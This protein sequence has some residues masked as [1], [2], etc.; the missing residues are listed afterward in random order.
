MFNPKPTL[1]STA[2][3]FSLASIGANAAPTNY[4]NNNAG[5]ITKTSSSSSYDV[6]FQKAMADKQTASGM[7][8]HF[9]SKL[10]K[11]TFA[12]APEGMAKPSLS[13]VAE[14]SKMQVAADFYL[15]ELTG[16][17]P[18]KGNAVT[19]KLMYMHDLGKG[20]RIAK[21]HQEIAGVEVF[22]REYNVMLDA[23]Y[24]LVAGSG[25]FSQN[26]LPQGQIAPDF[27]FGQA[28]TAIST[29][30]SDMS[31]GQVNVQL[32]PSD[33]AN[34][35]DVFDASASV[36]SMVFDTK[37]RAKK[38]YFDDDNGLV[39]AYYVEVSIADENSVD[40]TFYSY[41]IN[42]I[43]GKILFKHDLVAHNDFTYRAYAHEDGYP[44]QG[45]N[46]DVIPQLQPG[47]DPSEILDAP[48]ITLPFYSTLSTQ[49]PWLD[50]DATTT[51]G[52][53]AFAY[54]DVIAPQGFTTGD[55]TAETTAPNTFDYSINT[56]QRANSFDNRKAAIVNLFYMSNF[57]HDYYYDY[58]FDEA[59]GNAQLS[60]FDRGGLGG[61]PL[62]LE[63]QDSSGLN[64]ANMATPADG[65]S[66]RMQQFLWNDKDAVVGTDWGTTVTL[67]A[68][69][70]L[71][72]SSQLASFGALQY[73]DIVGEVVRLIDGD[74]ALGS[75]TDGCEA[76]TNAADLVGKIAIID[77]G[78]CNFTVKVFNAQQAGAVAALVVNNVDDGTPAPMGGEDDAVTIPSMGLNFEEG[79]IIY[80]EIDSDGTIEVEMFSNFPLRDSTF[81]NAIIAHE[82]GHYI[83]NR[84]IGNASGLT[85]FQGRAMGEGWAD[86]H[87]LLFVTSEEDLQLAG[88]DQLQT[89]YAVGSFVADFFT[90][91]RRAPYSTN[92]DINPLSFEDITTGAVPE[93]LTETTNASPHGAGEVWAVTLWDMYVSLVNTHGFDEG[94]DRM[95]RYIIEGYKMTPISPTY[96]EARDAILASVLATNPEDFDQSIAVFARRGMGLGAVSPD[97]DDPDLTGVVESNLTQLASFTGASVELNADFDGVTTGFCTA[98]G[99]LDNGET[100]T[101]TVTINNNGSEAL[102][103]I[104]G[105]LVVLSDHEVSFANDGLVEFESVSAFTSTSVSD[106]EITMLGAGTADTLEIEVQFPEIT[107]GD[108]TIQALPL[109]FTTLVNLDFDL[110]AP[111][112]GTSVSDMETAALF[113]DFSEN[114]IVGGSIA[115]GTLGT[116]TGN[117]SFFSS[118]NP[119]VD[120]G[121]QTMFLN[122]NTFVSDVAFETR[123]VEVGFAGDFSIEFW[124]SYLLEDG[125]DGGVVE[126]SINGTEWVDV[127]AVGGVFDVGYN[128]EFGEIEDQALSNRAV[129]TGRNISPDFSVAGN[130]EAIS[131]GDTLNGSL[132]QFRFRIGTDSGSSDL[133]WFI[134]NVTFNNIATPLFSEIVAGDS[135]PLESCDNSLPKLDISSELSITEGNSGAL[136]VAATDRNGDALTYSWTQTAGTSVNL[137]GADTETVTFNSP[138][139]SSDETLEFAV[140]VNDGTDTVSATAIVNVANVTPT[141][142]ETPSSSS[143]GGAMGWLTMLLLPVA[144]IRRRFK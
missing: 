40:S 64:N 24:S 107:A 119:G 70:G 32:T 7:K 14:E 59:S 126:I 131:F 77:R 89:G 11:T 130:Q 58:G 76:P 111:V 17:S 47:N 134:D 98:D 96:T 75:V 78:G 71:L 79:H 135:I 53:N 27:N 31:N 44:I 143:G 13:G 57:L 21:Y 106:I 132:V 120:L 46:G 87:A 25:F 42:A 8:S 65:G 94:R 118:T 88:N 28:S 10:G 22:N 99:V 55:I 137:V 115:A 72:E 6:H 110:V 56:E 108:E 16:V 127:T 140:S 123:P 69:V 2:I 30:V 62:L 43:T 103:N 18:A 133:G 91:I 34:G 84:L 60:N 104:T 26:L 83:Q 105:Q 39:A 121:A 116:D 29:A 9:D 117:T 19:A 138:T 129:F 3:A 142:T 54:A 48:L 74:D 128:A 81:D 144:F 85:N 97:R 113:E 63:A 66:P 41:V 38:V 67:P 109:S 12:W 125:F 33:A 112:N 114:V 95:S 36:A 68:E 73:S 93:G 90:G 139:I 82:F 23:E 80:N 122:N 136:S 86:V 50:A 51:S 124:H 1:L 52:N 37:P 141:P 100:G 35:Y 102:E 49:D 45:P 92:L 15:N 101:L 5:A 61:D 4:I 20:S